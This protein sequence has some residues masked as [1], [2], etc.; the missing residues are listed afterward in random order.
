MLFLLFVLSSLTGRLEIGGSVCE[1]FSLGFVPASHRL[2]C[3]NFVRGDVSGSTSSED[4]E[5][6]LL[7]VGTRS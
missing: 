7:H 1:S 6:S 4:L 3:L 5:I 2:L